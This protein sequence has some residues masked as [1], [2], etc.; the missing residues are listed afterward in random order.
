MELHY[1][2]YQKIKIYLDKIQCAVQNLN[3]LKERTIFPENDAMIEERLT[4]LR[5]IQAQLVDFFLKVQIS[6]P[7]VP[8]SRCK[9]I[10]SWYGATTLHSPLSFLAFQK[11]F[12]KADMQVMDQIRFII[13]DE[14]IV[15]CPKFLFE[16]HLERLKRIQLAETKIRQA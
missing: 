6:V 8:P 4:E 2:T 16:K 15:P 3:Q 13:A 5:L 7:Y 1:K 12:F 10:I 11:D 9:A 14:N